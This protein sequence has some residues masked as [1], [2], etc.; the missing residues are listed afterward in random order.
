[1]VLTTSAAVA[2]MPPPPQRGTTLP[3]AYNNYNS[4][5]SIVGNGGGNN[6]RQQQHAKAA[7]AHTLPS[8]GGGNGKGD[9]L[10]RSLNEANARRTNTDLPLDSRH[11]PASVSILSL[12]N[13]DNEALNFDN[14]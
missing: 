2:A 3:A 5:G 6:N 9:V 7:R 12:P 10:V 14:R 13:S 11:A 1:M 4:N 8:L